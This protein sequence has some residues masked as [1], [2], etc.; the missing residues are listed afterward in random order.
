M[1]KTTISGEAV[2]RLGLEDIERLLGQW[3]LENAALRKV[4][5]TQQIGVLVEPAIQ[6][7]AGS[8]TDVPSAP[9]RGNGHARD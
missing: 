2:T 8:E 1:T 7:H 6:S 5:A 3:V 4:I 9:A